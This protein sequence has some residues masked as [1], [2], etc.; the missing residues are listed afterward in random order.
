MRRFIA[1]FVALVITSSSFAQDKMSIGKSYYEKAQNAWN[2]YNR[3]NY[4]SKAL[5][6]LQDAAKEGFGEACYLLGNMYRYGYGT[7]AD[8]AIAVRM[9]NRGFEFGWGDGYTELGDMYLFGEIADDGKQDNANAFA[10]Y[11][12]GTHSGSMEER[13]R[14]GNRVAMC[15]YYGWGVLPN[16]QEAYDKWDKKVYHNEIPNIMRMIAEFYATG[17]YV[18]PNPGLAATLLYEAG[19]TRWILDAVHLMLNNN[20]SSVRLDSGGLCSRLS[21]LE[22]AIKKLSGE[23]LAKAQYL[24]ALDRCREGNSG[25]QR[26]MTAETA[27]IAS[28]NGGYAPAQW[29]LADWYRRGIKLSKNFVKAQELHDKAAASD[30]YKHEILWTIK[31]TLVETQVY[32]IE[33][34]GKLPD[35]YSIFCEDSSNPIKLGLSENNGYVTLRGEHQISASHITENIDGSVLYGGEVVVRQRVHV[36]HYETYMDGY[37]RYYMVHKDGGAKYGGQDLFVRFVDVEGNWVG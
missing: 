22:D 5:P 23:D 15:Y 16:R 28:A 18:E 10:T 35:G 20:I 34:R 9:Y 30:M 14:S 11:V 37:L 2:D 32:E 33:F 3:E 7:T 12:K 13:V 27:L 29:L 6:Y 17:M 24:Y 1:I 25:W 21:M 26:S 36:N 19:V 4:Y 8:K 31:T